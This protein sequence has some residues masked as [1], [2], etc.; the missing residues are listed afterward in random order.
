MARSSA[1]DVTS[2]LDD[3][4]VTPLLMRYERVAESARS[5]TDSRPVARYAGLSLLFL[6][7]ETEA[8]SSWNTVTS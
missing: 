3:D 1:D 2:T 7:V 5:S 4:S 8:G 6:M